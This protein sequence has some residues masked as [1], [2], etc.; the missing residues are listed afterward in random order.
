MVDVEGAVIK[1]LDRKLLGCDGHMSMHPNDQIKRWMFSDT[2]PKRENNERTL[3]V[4]DL[5]ADHRY[6]LG[7]FHAGRVT[8]LNPP[9]NP[10]RCDLHPRW[11]RSGTRV[12]I[13]SVHEGYRAIYLVDVS[14][15]I[16]REKVAT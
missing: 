9:M 11:D 7:R 3:F 4:Y 14:S 13:D 8:P 16:S 6:D 2:Y 5:N 12:T 15:V 1:I 10:M